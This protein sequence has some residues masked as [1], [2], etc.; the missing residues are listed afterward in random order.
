MA[1]TVSTA[2]GTVYAKLKSSGVRKFKA[3]TT[4]NATSA[5]HERN[6]IIRARPAITGL[7]L[8]LARE[9]FE[10]VTN[11]C[12]APKELGASEASGKDDFELER[13]QDQQA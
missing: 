6:E 11:K 1:R 2:G 3:Q 4:R 12:Q 9:T 8:A 5:K 10:K 7:C 13:S